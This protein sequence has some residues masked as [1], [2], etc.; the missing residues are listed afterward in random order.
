MKKFLSIT[1]AF[2][3]L[4]TFAFFAVGSSDLKEKIPTLNKD[5]ETTE[6][7][8]ATEP[9]FED[10]YANIENIT[11]SIPPIT[12]EDIQNEAFTNDV[13]AKKPKIVSA[14]NLKGT[15]LA[16]SNVD[17]T[18]SFGAE[19]AIDNQFESCW[20]V[21]TT[22]GGQGAKIRF[23]L[24]EKSTINGFKMVNGN[25][26]KP[27]TNIYKSNGQV[28]N[29][30]LTFSDGSSKTFTAN[31]NELASNEYEYFDFDAPVVTEYIILTVNSGYVGQKYTENV[32]IGEVGVY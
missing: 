13:T 11:E 2:I 21:S 17:K 3:V 6:P 25:I 19:K 29:F 28:K 30:T 27:E 24:K 23:D 12:S 7:T 26:Y 32:A 9:A 16:A 20:C 5:A 10:I 18:R 8:E 15:V 1:M 31:Y 4:F 22:N 14:V